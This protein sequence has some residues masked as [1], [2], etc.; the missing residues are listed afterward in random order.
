MSANINPVH[1][2]VATNLAN[3]SGSEE[4][5]HPE[6]EKA[7][8]KLQAIYDTSKK[9]SQELDRSNQELDRN[10]QMVA[11]NKQ[12]LDRNIQMV[13]RNKQELAR[14][15]QRLDNLQRKL[16]Q[17][18]ERAE[19]LQ[20]YQQLVGK[21]IFGFVQ[22]IKEMGSS[23]IRIAGYP[24]APM[25]QGTSQPIEPQRDPGS[26]SSPLSPARPVGKKK[27]ASDFLLG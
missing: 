8:K 27:S 21:M 4:P 2:V 14:D 16:D 11:R 9:N 1:P 10:I 23:M 12:E 20:D 25:L 13:A 26:A 17:I 7:I 6:V 3:S 22:R 15:N 24:N 18:G 5:M 19:E